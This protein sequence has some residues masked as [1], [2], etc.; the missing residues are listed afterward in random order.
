MGWRLEVHRIILVEHSAYQKC[1]KIQGPLYSREET[2]HLPQF[3][4]SIPL[5]FQQKPSLHKTAQKPTSAGPL[6]L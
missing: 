4:S 1:P 3:T 6:G 5:P 2:L